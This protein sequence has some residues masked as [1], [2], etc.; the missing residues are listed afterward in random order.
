MEKKDAHEHLS[1]PFWAVLGELLFAL[2]TGIF[3]WKI[4]CF[5]QAAMFLEVNIQFIWSASRFP[6]QVLPPSSLLTSSDSSFVLLFSSFLSGGKSNPRLPCCLQS[7]ST[8]MRSL[9]IGLGAHSHAYCF[10]VQESLVDIRGSICPS[11]GF[12]QNNS[13]LV[14]CPPAPWLPPSHSQSAC[15]SGQNLRGYSIPK[16]GGESLPQAA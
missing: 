2:T 8:P 15:F 12:T 7:I 6:K 14:L 13:I 1:F 16:M 3:P 11:P 10:M 4:P 5:P 9:C